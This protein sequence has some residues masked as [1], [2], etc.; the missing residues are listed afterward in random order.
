[1][2]YRNYGLKISEIL[3]PSAY[4][5]GG[6]ISLPKVIINPGRNWQPYFPKYEPQFNSSIDTA[7]CTVWGSQNCLETYLKKATGIEPNYSELFNYI[8]AGI[9][10][11]GADPHKVLES[12]RKNKL[13]P[14][15]LL[16]FNESFTSLEQLT[17]DLITSAMRQEAEKW[18]HELKH[19]YVWNTKQTKDERK[20]KIREYLQ[21][22]PLAVSVTAWIKQGD[23]YVDGGQPNT[24]WCE[25]GKEVS[26][27]WL[28]FDSYDHSEKVISF[29]HNIQICKRFYLQ[30]KAIKRFWLW[31]ILQRLW[32]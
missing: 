17:P 7:G 2:S 23:V 29:D 31:W 27:G 18:P 9:K 8:L 10:P 30:K 4:I 13:I 5:L 32:R 14:N 20:A 15:E 25:L 28:I 11:P 22:S 12:I 19:E 21:Y 3:D 1:M 26:N 6:V 16:P 24:H